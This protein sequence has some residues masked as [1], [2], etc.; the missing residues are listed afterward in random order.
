LMSGLNGVTLTAEEQEVSRNY[1]ATLAAAVGTLDFWMYGAYHGIKEQS[2]LSFGQ[3]QGLW[4]SHTHVWTGYRP[5]PSWLALQM[6]N[7]HVGAGPMLV[8]AAQSVPAFDLVASNTVYPN[9]SLASVY[10]FNTGT[11]YSVFAINKKLDGT[12]NGL[13]FGDGCTPFTLHLPFT[14]AASI[15]LYKLEGDPR[16][17]NRRQLN[18]QIVTQSISTACFSQE[19]VVNENTGGRTNGIP[20]GGIYLYVF[21]GCAAS[22]LATNP[23]VVINQAPW[24]EDPTYSTGIQFRAVFDQPVF[25]LTAGDIALT[26]TAGATSMTVT[27]VAGSQHTIFDVTVQGMQQ[28]GTVVLTIPVNAATNAAGCGNTASTSSDNEV[29]FNVNYP[30]NT[31]VNATPADCTLGQPVVVALQASVFSDQNPGDYHTAS[32]WQ[33]STN[34]GFTTRAWDSGTDT[35]HLT[36]VTTPALGYSTRYYWRVRYADPINAWSAYSTATWFETELDPNGPHAPTNQL[37]MDA[38]TGVSLTPAL[39][40]SGFADPNMGDTHAASQW[41]ISMQ[42]NFA[43]LTWDSGQDAAN[44]T[45][46]TSPHLWYESRYC[47]RVR[48]KDSAGIWGGYSSPTWFETLEFPHVYTWTN[49]VGGNWAVPGNWIPYGY[50]NGTGDVAVIAF[51]YFTGGPGR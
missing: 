28:P 1:G 19:F 46:I 3:D 26:G 29:F 17:T 21:E 51:E 39:Y 18:F 45:N 5:H 48:Y 49:A 47:W 11:T 27:E 40:A 33:V 23:A 8:A 24:Q 22:A 50:P 2:F 6:F 35:T 43:S 14:N 4:T 15:M 44:L 12:H 34:A 7:K 25:G 16:E 9:V 36:S 31:P 38:A 30:P 20:P 41:Q 32:Q 13:D 42:S 37:P 10:A